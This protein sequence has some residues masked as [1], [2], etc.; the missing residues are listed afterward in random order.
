MPTGIVESVAQGA[1]ARGALAILAF[2]PLAMGQMHWFAKA[3][4]FNFPSWGLHFTIRNGN[5]S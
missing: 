4:G 3:I 1:C 2:M 5:G